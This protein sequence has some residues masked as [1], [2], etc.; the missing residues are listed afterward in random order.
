[1]GHNVPLLTDMLTYSCFSSMTITGALRPHFKA[2]F[3]I[4]CV[5]GDNFSIKKE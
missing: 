2:I 3:V 4:Y 5:A 1:M